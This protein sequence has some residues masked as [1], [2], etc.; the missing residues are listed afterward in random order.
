MHRLA[1]KIVPDADIAQQI[2]RHARSV[3][4]DRNVPPSPPLFECKQRSHRPFLHVFKPA[5]SAL[6]I[7]DRAGFEV[8]SATC[9]NAHKAQSFGPRCESLHTLY[10]NGADQLPPQASRWELTHTSTGAT[11]PLIAGTRRPMCRARVSVL[12]ER[13]AIGYAKRV[14]TR[15]ADINI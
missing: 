5:R 12:F 3:N 11:S 4:I 15:S 6:G 13:A 8:G 9:R 1:G 2:L 7:A 10:I 14:R